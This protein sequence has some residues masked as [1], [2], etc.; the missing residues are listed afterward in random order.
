MGLG[1]L[2]L[3]PIWKNW[4]NRE[5]EPVSLGVGFDFQYLKTDT[6]GLGSVLGQNWHILTSTNKNYV[7]CLFRILFLI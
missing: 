7:L 2:I 6:I 4:K 1:N 3:K 5:T